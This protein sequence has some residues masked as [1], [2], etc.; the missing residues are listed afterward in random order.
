[1]KDFGFCEQLQNNLSHLGY[2]APTPI[3]DQAI[4]HGMAGKDV[5]GIANTGTGKTAAFLL[6]LIERVLKNPKH[7]T[8]LIIAPVRELAQQIEKELAG[9]TRGMR[10]G[11]MSAIGGTPIGPQIRK[12]ERAPHFII[13]TPGRITDLIN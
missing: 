7:E 11:Y 3:Q 8:V 12:I 13:G 5:L 4:G 2:E 6:P 10:L 9:F 1:F